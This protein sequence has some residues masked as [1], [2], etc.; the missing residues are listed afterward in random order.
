MWNSFALWSHEPNFS[1]V[2]STYTLWTS[3]CSKWHLPACSWETWPSPPTKINSQSSVEPKIHWLN[4][5]QILGKGL[6]CIQFP[7]VTFTQKEALVLAPSNTVPRGHLIW[8]QTTTWTTAPRSQWGPRSSIRRRTDFLNASVL[9][10][11][12]VMPQGSPN[13]EDWN[14]NKNWWAL[15]T[16]RW[17]SKLNPGLLMPDWEERKHTLPLSYLS[18]L[19]FQKNISHSVK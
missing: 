4:F 6:F 16:L 8:M 13:P 11:V 1:S 15:G 9:H 17:E 12:S 14:R 7:D 2:D 10:R 18:F 3:H 5:R 19:G